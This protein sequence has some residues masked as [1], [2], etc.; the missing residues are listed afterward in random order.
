MTKEK[1]E[2]GC[3]IE[4]ERDTETKKKY[5]YIYILRDRDSILAQP[6]ASNQ[7]PAVAARPCASKE[8]L[9]ISAANSANQ[10]WFPLDPH[11][12]HRNTWPRSS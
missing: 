8:R 2:K 7:I 10:A 4:S 9:N 5:I 1:R 11:E 12:P 6:F 3:M